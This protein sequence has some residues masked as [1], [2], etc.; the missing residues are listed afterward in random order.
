MFNSCDPPAH[1]LQKPSTTNRLLRPGLG[2]RQRVLSLFG[3]F[4]AARLA[5]LVEPPEQLKLARRL[6]LPPET[7]ERDEHLIAHARVALAYP[8]RAAQHAERLL[9][10]AAAH[11][12]A[13]QVVRG[14]EVARVPRVRA[15][16]QSLG[17][18]L[19]P[20]LAHD[21][22]ELRQRVRALGL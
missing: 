18:R 11:E 14:V 19:A 3:P 13:A 5:L 7:R 8:R 9:V 15:P 21:E 20:S 17:L 22:A 6:V 10:T 1:A 4:G 16:Q 12:Q 2:P